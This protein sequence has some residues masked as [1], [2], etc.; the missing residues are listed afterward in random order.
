[1]A[2]EQEYS[3]SAEPTIYFYIN[4]ETEFVEYVSMYTIFGIT[5][6]EKGK[7]WVMGSRDDLEKYYSPE[8]EIWSYEWDNSDD[9]PGSGAGLDPENEDDW[10]ISP[11]QDWAKGVDLKRADIEEVS[12]LVNS[13]GYISEEEAES[14][15][16]E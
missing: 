9:T 5:V 8:Y 12:R 14:I 10:E 6:R 4:K 7:K 11:V 1:M 15:P 3:I 2:E 16:G 13:G